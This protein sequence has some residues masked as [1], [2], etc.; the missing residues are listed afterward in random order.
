MATF[1]HRR[2]RILI[3]AGS[4]WI[5]LPALLTGCAVGG[6]NTI[7]TGPIDYMFDYAP[8]CPP[9]AV[10][11]PATLCVEKFSA[12][13][14]YGT[15]ALVYAE[16]RYTRRQYLSHRW[17]SSPGDMVS[18]FLARDLRH[19]RLFHAVFYHHCRPGSRYRIEGVVDEIFEEN[20]K[21]R[22]VAVLAATVTLIDSA[23]SDPAAAV[24]LQ[25]TYRAE[26]DCD[27]RTPRDI[28]AAMSLA[29]ERI[30]MAV[31]EDVDGAVKKQEPAGHGAM[32]TNRPPQP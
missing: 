12:A 10:S 4:L 14:A 21:D 27:G 19:A 30:S 20:R 2:C 26:T 28:A 15:D 11:F 22:W 23:A 31:L 25:K 9:R 32:E 18:A 13:P 5:L 3:F 6:K 29:M 8:P 16:D 24:R 1:I 17:R 7:M